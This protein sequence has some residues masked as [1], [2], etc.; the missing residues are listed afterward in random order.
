MYLNNFFPKQTF[1]LEFFLTFFKESS[2]FPPTADFDSSSCKFE[3][4]HLIRFNLQIVSDVDQLLNFL[5]RQSSDSS[6]NLD[7]HH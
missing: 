6:K 3:S 7:Q 4:D 1:N 2:C 5:L